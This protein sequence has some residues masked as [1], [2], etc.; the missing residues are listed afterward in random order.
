MLKNINKEII[1]LKETE[2]ME[3]AN[4][5]RKHAFETGEKVYSAWF[6]EGDTST[7]KII[8]DKAIDSLVK[9]KTFY[10][11]Q[12]GMP[13]LRL[14]I[15]NYMNEIFK[16]N[17]KPD[18]HSV[19]TGGMMG[20]RLVCDLILSD[21]DEVVI[22][23]PVWPNIKSSV[24]LKKSKIKEVSLTL[25]KKGWN[26]D[27][28]LL[29]K[30]I[31]SSTKM[32]F[33]NS[34]GNPT[35]WVITRD[36]QNK[37]LNHVRQTGS[38]L[39]SDEV[40]HQI[41]FNDTVAPSFLQISLPND[42]LIV[43]NSASKSFNMTGWRIGWLTHPVELGEHIAK[44][45]QI[46]TSGVPEFLQN[47]LLSALHNYKVITN[48]LKLNLIKSRDL[49]FARLKTWSRVECSVPEA[50]FYA[51]FKVK[52]M[53]NSLEF[54]KKLIVETKVGVAPGIAFGASGEGHLR[55]CF[56]ANEGFINTIMDRL[57]PVLNS[58]S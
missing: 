11:F 4:F 28:Q 32:V 55:I 13:N 49:M 3:V 46:T 31:S 19:V 24:L 18:N 23:G 2:I 36:Q 30:S 43:I 15:S 25:G 50:A 54:A 39:I 57:E 14:E 27:F 8:Y 52:G 9:G 41:I 38:W 56:A 10:T 26:L 40:Y 44:L 17:T 48:E 7:N 21:N 42:R 29:L 16:I 22:V 45:V 53:S 5:G 33:I 51:F 35:G 12:N 6:G 37:L 1:S 34:P 58:K 47:G 20:L